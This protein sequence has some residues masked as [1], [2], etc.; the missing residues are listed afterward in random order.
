M[1]V[2]VGV[3][4]VLTLLHAVYYQTSINQL[5]YVHYAEC[6]LKCLFDDHL[7]CKCCR[8]NKQSYKPCVCALLAR[9]CLLYY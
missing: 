7:C 3:R 6:L 4:S 8:I 1:L 2:L 9:V 5:Q